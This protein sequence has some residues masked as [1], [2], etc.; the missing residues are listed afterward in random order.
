MT[1]PALRFLFDQMVSVPALRQVRKRGLDVSHVLEVGL[2]GAS[3]ARVLAYAREE[4]RIVVTRNYQDFAPLVSAYVREGIAFP[5]VLFVPTS[6]PH[7]DPGGHV[8]ALVSWV[9]RA[10]DR[11]PVADTLGWL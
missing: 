4:G 10:G 5:G 9:D 3:D 7:G 8:K 2:G 11:N 6:I 1:D